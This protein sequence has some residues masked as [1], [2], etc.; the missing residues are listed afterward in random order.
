MHNG[1]HLRVDQGDIGRRAAPS[2]GRVDHG[3]FH[4]R[5]VLSVVTTLV[6]ILEVADARVHN[7]SMVEAQQCRART[8]YQKRKRRHSCSPLRS[9]GLL[10]SR[11]ASAG[12]TPVSA[13]TIAHPDT[14]ALTVPKP[15]LYGAPAVSNIRGRSRKTAANSRVVETDGMVLAGVGVRGERDGSEDGRKER[16]EHGGRGEKSVGERTRVV[17]GETRM[18]WAAGGRKGG[19]R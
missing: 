5:A 11:G 7:E 18:R 14:P 13:P 3:H 6:A 10:R 8:R 12:P 4:Q 2:A 16:G 9:R 15:H 1:R 19:Q 17:A